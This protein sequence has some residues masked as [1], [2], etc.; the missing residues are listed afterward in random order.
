MTVQQP[1]CGTE[2]G[3]CIVLPAASLTWQQ[4]LGFLAEHGGRDSSMS[5]EG[6]EKSLEFRAFVYTFRH[7]QH[8]WEDVGA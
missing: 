4:V 5:F 2:M 6:K 3:K 1:V 8:L 7:E